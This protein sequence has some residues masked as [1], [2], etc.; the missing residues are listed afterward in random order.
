[1]TQKVI[2]LSHLSSDLEEA[3]I[4]EWYVNEGQNLQQGEPLL[5]F[6]TAKTILEAPMPENALIE[7][8]HAQVGETIKPDSALL[9]INNA[10]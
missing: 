10:I 2:Y 3:V 5:A 9:S 1:M 6:E 7:K 8:I 4:R